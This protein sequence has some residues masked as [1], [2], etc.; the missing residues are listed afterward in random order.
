MAGRDESDRDKAAAREQAHGAEERPGVAQPEP[1][2]TVAAEFAA[3]LNVERDQD[4]AELSA[5]LSADRQAAVEDSKALAQSELPASKSAEAPLAAKGWESPEQS[6]TVDR[7]LEQ[8]RALAPGAAGAQLEF[9]ES[10]AR[11]RPVVARQPE[12][13]VAA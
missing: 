6:R 8:P 10:L 12:L 9:V 1:P 7:R 2:V 5:G 11:Q 3:A 13:Q 4:G